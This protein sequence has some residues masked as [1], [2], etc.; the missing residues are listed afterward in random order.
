MHES[1]SLRPRDVWFGSSSNTGASLKVPYN[2]SPNDSVPH[3]P[4]HVE[5]KLWG[6]TGIYVTGDSCPKWE[7]SPP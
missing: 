4:I 7:A 2:M 1:S 5:H 3:A 6:F